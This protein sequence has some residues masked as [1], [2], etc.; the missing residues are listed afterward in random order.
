MFRWQTMH[1]KAATRTLIRA[2]LA[3]VSATLLATG[4]GFVAIAK[5][6]KTM[7]QGVTECKAWCVKRHGS[8]PS[9]AIQ[10]C[11]RK[12]EAYWMCYG[13]DS[14]EVSCKD[15]RALLERTSPQLPPGME[16]NTDR[17]GADFG[18]FE[19]TR[20]SECQAAC[21]KDTRCRSW[22]FVRPRVQGVR[23]VCYLKNAMPPATPNNCCISGVVP[24]GPA[25]VS[26]NFPPPAS[27]N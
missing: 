16:D 12:C 18:H 2:M 19:V 8:A 23:A 11:Y 17:P 1:P 13:S 4:L 5:E 20:A 25:G 7:L 24:R 6:K 22:T 3:L 9:N 14:T 10:V 15:G 26:P 21:R 27:Q